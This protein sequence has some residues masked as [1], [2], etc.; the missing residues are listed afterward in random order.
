MIKK[1]IVSIFLW[2]LIMPSSYAQNAPNKVSPD[3]LKYGNK[4]LLLN[5]AGLR[6]EFFLSLY[7]GSLYLMEKSIDGEAIIESDQPMAIRLYIKSSL[8]TAKK[9]E[10]ATVNGLKKSGVN[11]MEIQ[12]H[13]DALVAT[14][15]G[16]VS[17][18]D[19]YELIH[20]P[21]NGIHVLRNKKRVTIIRSL[22]FKKALFSIWLSKKPV[23]QSLKRQMLGI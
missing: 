13:I 22:A 1:M 17:E 2:V 10:E 18:G 21:E 9:M 8:I 4:T 23:Q 15:E 11:M 7:V 16:G 14:F 3:S 19:V 6:K 5:G 20:I 12:E